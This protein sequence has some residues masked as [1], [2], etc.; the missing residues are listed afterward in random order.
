MASDAYVFRV[1][2]LRNITLTPPYFHTGQVWGL[3]QAVAIIGPS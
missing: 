2:T 3:R 1:P